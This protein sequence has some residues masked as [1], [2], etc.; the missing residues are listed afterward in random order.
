[1]QVLK[2]S[3]GNKKIPCE[4]CAQPFEFSQTRK[5]VAIT[6]VVMIVFAPTAGDV[7]KLLPVVTPVIAL[8]IKYLVAIVLFVLING[9]EQKTG[10]GEN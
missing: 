9:R 8:L 3:M 10:M 5:W 2:V 4:S 1:L 7:L 6:V